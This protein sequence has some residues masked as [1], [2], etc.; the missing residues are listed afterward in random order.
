MAVFANV[1][2]TNTF[3]SWRIRTNQILT[4]LNQYTVNESAFY[5][6]TLTANVALVAKSTANVDF[7]GTSTYLNLKPSKFGNTVSL[8]G[9]ARLL[10][11]TTVT[12]GSNPHDTVLKRSAMIRWVGNT[13]I[14]TANFGLSANSGVKVNSDSLRQ[15]VP[16]A[17]GE[18]QMFWGGAAVLGGWWKL[19]SSGMG[20]VF[21]GVSSADHAAPA[22]GRVEVYTKNETVGDPMLMV[23][24]ATGLP[25]TIAAPTSAINLPIGNT[26]QRPSGGYANGSIRYSSQLGRFEGFAAGNW[27][28]LLT[29]AGKTIIASGATPNIF[30][31]DVN[32]FVEYTGTGTATG[33][34]A[35]PL[36]G[37]ERILLC[38]G[39]SSFTAGANLLINGIPSGSTVTVTA[40]D[41]LF[42]YAYT[43]TQFYMRLQSA[44][45]AGNQTYTR[46]QRGAP[47]V[48][49]ALTGTVTP[50][51]NLGNNWYGTLTGNITLA[52]PTNLVAGQSGIIAITN[53][54]TP[55]TIAYGSYFK[56]L[57]GVLPTLTA[58]ANAKDTLAYYVDSATQI[59]ITA[60]GD[61]R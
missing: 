28:S 19:E 57:S 11:G 17:N 2:L 6:N 29:D 25:R 27:N 15:I 13:G 35:A 34:A 45:P 42:V 58:D 53:G 44:A 47:V 49:P 36:A 39:A 9:G 24:F 37:A 8:I 33:F 56:G 5:A 10:Q 48:L 26:A 30:A 61:I 41:V 52:N 38:T 1:A 12:T 4:R 55:Y 51:F 50:D 32:P 22:S 7:L 59:T 60:L 20:L 3:D 14:T 40:G 31:A 21:N 46:A 54:A 23:R 18:M 16:T 43:T